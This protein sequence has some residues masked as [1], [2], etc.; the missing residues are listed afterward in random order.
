MPP[1]YGAFKLASVGALPNIV[2][3]FPGEHWSDGKADEDIVPG[4]LVEQINVSGKKYW[5]RV[6]A[7]GAV[8]PLMAVAM[9]TIDIP[10]A[11]PGSFYAEALG[12]NEIKNLPIKAGQYVHAWHSGAFQLTLFAPDAGIAPGHLMA[13]DPA[14]ARPTGKP[15]TGS[16]IRTV[17]GANAFFVVEEFRPL[18]DT[19]GEGI[20]TVRSV[21]S[22]F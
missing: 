22:Q 16:W 6:T 1:A 10:D 13:Y 2:V 5:R 17:T 18:P 12:P 9:R 4:E 19:P 11:N 3:A 7:V 14:G 20:L 15:G 21:R 8:T